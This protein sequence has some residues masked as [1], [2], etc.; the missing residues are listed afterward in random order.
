MDSGQAIIDVVGRAVKVEK[1]SEIGVWSR[2]G[3]KYAMAGGGGGG[4]AAGG[5]V[6][7]R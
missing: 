3:K 4:G 6:E 5:G 1:G 2:S 7:K